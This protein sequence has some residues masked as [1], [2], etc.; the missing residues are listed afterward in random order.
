VNA[1]GGWRQ[2]A[3]LPLQVPACIG[4]CG[5]AETSRTG[6]ATVSAS[7]SSAFHP[8]HRGMGMPCRCWERTARAGWQSTSKS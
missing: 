4:W 8:T 3:T 5:S 7:V 6:G 1:R 2:V